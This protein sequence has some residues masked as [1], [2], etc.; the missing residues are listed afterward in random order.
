[1][2][3]SSL[4]N[5]LL[6]KVT[7]LG[8]SVSVTHY[9]LSLGAPDAV[10]GIPA[11]TYSAGATIEMLL[12]GKAAQQILTG[13]GIYV[14]TDAVTFTKTAV[15]DGDKIK[16]ANNLYYIAESVVPNSIGNIIIFYTVNLTFI[17]DFVG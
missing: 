1:M 16:D 4:Y 5:V 8:A 17:G 2:D 15:S 11:K 13:I 12:F 14:K 6:A 7:G 9:T 10:T 3:V